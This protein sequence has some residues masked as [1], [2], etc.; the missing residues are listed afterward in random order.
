MEFLAKEI[1]EGSFG[2]WDDKTLST[3]VPFPPSF[4][5]T[6]TKGWYRKILEMINKNSF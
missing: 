6:A 3:I 1:E 4:P 2:P 5:E